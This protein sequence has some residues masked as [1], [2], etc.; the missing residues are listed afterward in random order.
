MLID[1]EPQVGE[2]ATVKT[3][4]SGQAWGSMGLGARS[5]EMPVPVV[6]GG[7]DPWAVHIT[8]CSDM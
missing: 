5:L 3:L 1:L 4:L 7:K 6:L 2:V 8:L